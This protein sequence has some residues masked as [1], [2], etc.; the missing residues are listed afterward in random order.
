MIANPT[1][2]IAATFNGMWITNLGICLA[3]D[4]ISKGYIQAKFAPYDG[5]HILATEGRRLN[6]VD[7]PAARASDPVLDS[8][9]T[10]LVAELH[11]LS[12]KTADAQF[13]AVDAQ[14]PGVPVHAVCKFAD[15]TY[16]SI[17]DCYALAASDSV[18]AEVFQATMAE[19][20]RQAGLTVS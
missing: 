20:A 7:V 16:Y 1:P 13:L 8:T 6:M 2:I 11:R 14:K 15:G 10:A 9:L 3:V 4:N 18:F 19:I 17:K 5:T 12:N